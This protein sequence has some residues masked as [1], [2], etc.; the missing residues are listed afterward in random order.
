MEAKFEKD[1]EDGEL[2]EC[3]P[4]PTPDDKVPEK[5]VAA[6][7]GRGGGEGGAV[8]LPCRSAWGSK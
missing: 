3:L 7:E 6:N 4:V 8:G 5:A 1:F 2:K